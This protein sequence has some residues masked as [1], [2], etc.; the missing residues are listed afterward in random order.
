M[1]DKHVG[2]NNIINFALIAH[3]LKKI[4]FNLRFRFFLATFKSKKRRFDIENH[5]FKQVVTK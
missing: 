1:P 3:H 4:I 2:M 5:N